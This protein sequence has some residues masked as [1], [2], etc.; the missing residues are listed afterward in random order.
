MEANFS[1]SKTLIML[2]ILSRLFFKASSC[3]DQNRLQCTGIVKAPLCYMQEKGTGDV[4]LLLLFCLL[5]SWLLSLFSHSVALTLHGII[6]SMLT[7]NSCFSECLRTHIYIISYL[8]SLSSIAF[9]LVA[10]EFP[11]H[12]R[13]ALQ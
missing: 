3:C 11:K 10:F 9:F 7:I 13:V 6:L 1:A 2:S 8:V 5:L 4:S 12:Q